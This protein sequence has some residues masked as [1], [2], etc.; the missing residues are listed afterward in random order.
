M[1][2]GIDEVDETYRRGELAQDLVREEL[3][4]VHGPWRKPPELLDMNGCLSW[5]QLRVQ[6]AA[7]DIDVVLGVADAR[8]PECLCRAAQQAHAA[9]TA[10]PVTR[11]QDWWQV[12]AALYACVLLARSLRA[13]HGCWALQCPG[14][15][16]QR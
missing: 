7:S 2:T 14:G 15:E 1:T 3:C 4:R 6:D 12:T 5:A 9:A 16:A 11:H 10:V 13:S 8:R